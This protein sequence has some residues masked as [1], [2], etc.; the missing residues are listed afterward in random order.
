MFKCQSNIVVL[1]KKGTCNQEYSEASSTLEF[2][3]ISQHKHSQTQTVCLHIVYAERVC[4]TSCAICIPILFLIA[5]FTA[6][7]MS[8]SFVSIDTIRE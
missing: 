2:H 7:Y 5:V 1:N 8:V 3:R 4:H 6:L